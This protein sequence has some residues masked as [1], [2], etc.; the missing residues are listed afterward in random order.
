MNETKHPWGRPLKFQSIQ[1][2]ENK[3][4]EYFLNITDD[5][6]DNPASITWLAIYLD[7]S[8]ETLCNLERRSEYFDAIK[9][10]KDRVEFAYEKRLI[11]KWWS[12]EIFALKNL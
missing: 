2:L 4:E 5:K 7:T 6:W 9:K 1:E 11:R 12:W 10:A 3:I 8:R